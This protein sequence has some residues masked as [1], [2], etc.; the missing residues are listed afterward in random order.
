MYV[1][2]TFLPTLVDRERT[3]KKDGGERG[4]K[5]KERLRKHQDQSALVPCHF[6]L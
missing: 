1:S 5:N 4:E 2:H 6:D 3:I